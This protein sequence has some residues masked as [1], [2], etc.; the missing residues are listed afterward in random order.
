VD[1]PEGLIETVGTGVRAGPESESAWVILASFENRHAAEHTVALL[2]HEFRHQALS[3]N[4]A[5]FMIIHNR[6]G[7]FTLVQSH[8]LT[9]R[10]FAASATKLSAFILAGLWGVKAAFNGAKTAVHARH[11]RQS[12]VGRDDK[13]LAELLDT[14]GP[15]AAGMVF[16]CTDKHMAQDVAALVAK[17]AIDSAHHSRTEFLALVDRLGGNYDW[18][19]PAVV[20]PAAKATKHRWFHRGK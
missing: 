13:R 11:E 18:V 12:H 1:E 20:E 8:V 17:R 15:H 7:S 2:S 3:G 10:G 6:D 4:A 19:R 5:A 14:I 16:V 9:A